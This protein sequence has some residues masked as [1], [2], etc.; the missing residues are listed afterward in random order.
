MTAL[1]NEPEVVDAET[2]LALTYLRLLTIS[3]SRT[4]PVEGVTAEL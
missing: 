1:T 3:Y 4:S 2:I